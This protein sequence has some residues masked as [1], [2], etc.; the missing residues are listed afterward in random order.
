MKTIKMY[1]NYSNFH[2]LGK[3]AAAPGDV[4]DVAEIV[5][6]DSWELAENQYGEELIITDNGVRCLPCEV[7]TEYARWNANVTPVPY[8]VIR[9]NGRHSKVYLKANIKR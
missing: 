9:K 8:F 3:F 1:L 7:Q 5:L 4:F 6:P 2:K